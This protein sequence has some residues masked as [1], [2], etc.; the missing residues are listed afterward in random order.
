MQINFIQS[1]YNLKR[2]DDISNKKSIIHNLNPVVKILATILYII[3]VISFDK[4]EIIGLLPLLL[5][6]VVT[7]YLGNIPFKSIWKISLIGLPL[8]LGIGIFN[9]IFERTII[10]YMGI[11]PI[12]LGMISFT[13]LILKGLLT[14]S[15]GILLISSTGIEGLSRG[16]RFL[17]VP[18]IFTNQ[19]VFTYRYIFV[20]VESV[21]EVYNAYMLRAPNE[22]GVNLKFCGSLLGQVLLRSF[23]RAEVVYNA[24]ILRG[25]SGEYISLENERFKKNDFIY[26]IFWLVFFIVVKYI[27]IPLFLGS[28]VMGGI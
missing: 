6:I 25:F 23:D 20:L 16:L 17:K 18:K 27:N 26:I 24:M 14:I 22:K 12:T 13:S 1:I 8:L 11:I 28:L 10:S 3:T 7:V 19:I 21:G 2:V 15:S 9:L 5:F 4:Y